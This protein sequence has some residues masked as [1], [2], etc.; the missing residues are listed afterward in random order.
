MEHVG[1]VALS[2]GGRQSL[3]VFRALAFG[4]RILQRM[5]STT[6]RHLERDGILTRR[7]YPEVPA[8]VE[9]TLTARGRRLLVPVRSLA[10]WLLEERPAIEKFRR[11]HDRQGKIA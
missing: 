5:L 7:L 4:R 10:G 2:E 3:A 6:L 8:R 11:F 9:Y 1:L